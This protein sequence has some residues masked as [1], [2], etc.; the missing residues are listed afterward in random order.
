M[1]VP[2][3][4]TRQVLV[5][6]VPATMLVLSGIVTSATNEALF[7]QLGSLG[8]RVAVGVVGVDG[9]SVGDAVNVPDSS[10]VRAVSWETGTSLAGGSVAATAWVSV[11][12]GRAASVGDCVPQPASTM[13]ISE[14][15]KSILR[16][17]PASFVFPRGYDG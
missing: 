12:V 4:L 2:V 17:I 1:H 13:A 7:V 15:I 11:D 9:V 14:A 6:G 10:G 5:K 8:G 3:L 16:I